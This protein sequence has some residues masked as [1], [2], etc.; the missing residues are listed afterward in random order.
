MESQN[1]SGGCYCGNIRYKIKEIPHL[2]VNCHCHNC[3]RAIGAQ[4]VAWILLKKKF[5][6]WEKGNPVRYQTET[7]AWR[8]FCPDCGSSLTYE[9]PT[10]S[11]NIDVTTGSLDHPDDFPPTMDAYKKYRIPWVSLIREEDTKHD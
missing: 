3:R 10:R 2:S 7:K 4:S 1:I 8:T 9:S 11:D 5:F 6:S